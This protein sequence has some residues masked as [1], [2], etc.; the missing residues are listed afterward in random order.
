MRPQHAEF[1]YPSRWLAD[2]TVAQRAA[3][4]AEAA[5]S[6]DLPPLA[7]G[8]ARPKRSVYEP[9][10]AYGPPGSR[11]ASWLGSHQLPP[12]DHNDG[13]AALHVHAQSQPAAFTSTQPLH[14]APRRHLSMAQ[15]HAWWL[16]RSSSLSPFPRELL[17]PCPHTTIH[18]KMPLAMTFHR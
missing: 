9:V 17:L 14:A 3:E 8:P 5:R 16:L 7:R 4:R 10:A 15:A 2:Q 11:W 12:R 18:P 13:P 1:T 6:L